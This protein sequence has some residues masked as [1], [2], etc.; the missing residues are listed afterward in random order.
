M[1][2]TLIGPI[3]PY[4]GG[5]S[6]FNTLLFKH[7]K[8]SKQDVKLV[9]WKRRFP[10]FLYPGKS[11]FEEGKKNLIKKDKRFILDFFNPFTWL[12]TF[13]IIK[14]NKSDLLILHW[15]TPFL[16]H[17]FWFILF[18]TK[19]FTDTQ[20]MLVCHN[21]LPHEKGLFDILSANLVFRNVDYFIVHSKEDQTNLKK[22]KP[23]AKAYLAFHP[24]YEAFKYVGLNKKI[25]KDLK[26]NKKTILFFGY[27]RKYKGLDYLLKAMPDVL[28]KVD[29]DLLI[30]GEF[31]KGKQACLDLINMLDIK[32]N[33]KIVSEY[34]PDE[35]V[36]NYFTS[37]NLV[38]LPYLSATQ[39]GIVQLAFGFEKPVITTNVGGLP[40]AVSDGKTGFIVP[41][42]DSNALTNKII[43]FF[44]ENKEKEFVKNIINKKDQFSW[45]KYVKIIQ[46]TMKT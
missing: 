10:E 46:R 14:N 39:S 27:V 36:K 20:T 38:V 43:K 31:W 12:K 33:V 1:R 17:V 44:T 6:H 32:K 24:T 9:S 42:R 4:K 45:D 16:G 30:V 29:C 13:L 22:I 2:I 37:S 11:Q 15:V 3:N 28:R 35:D 34:V 5:I 23:D 21:V 25:K 40:N 7:L 41:P 26:L 18:L 8:F 19:K